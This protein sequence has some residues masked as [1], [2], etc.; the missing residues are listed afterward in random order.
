M[1]LDYQVCFQRNIGFFSREEQQRLKEAKV[2]VAGVGGVGG[3]EAATLAKMGLGELVVFDPGVFDEPDMNRQLGATVSNIGRNKAVA[4]AEMLREINPFMK[5]TALDQAP[6]DD[7]ELD[8]LLAGAAVAIDAIDY[9]GFDYKV[10]FAQA[11]R[12]AG[13]L[14]FTA[15]ISG[16]GTTMLVLDPAGMTLE[17]LYNAPAD[18]AQWPHHRLPLAQMLGPDRFGDLVRDMDEGRRPYLSNCAG[19]AMLNGGLV[20][21]EIA[22]LIT[23]KRLRTEL[24]IAPEAIY[25]DLLRR[26]FKT[27][28]VKE[29]HPHAE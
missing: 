15:P 21:T 27:V 28:N 16:V 29:E 8:R 7:A 19:I 23:G 22:L 6:T 9:L 3:I 24:V 4:T 13:L 25:V 1:N 5:L 20:A 11:V 18:P 17:E 26:E 12:R 2:V 10:K 14:N